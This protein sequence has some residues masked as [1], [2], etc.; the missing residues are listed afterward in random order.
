MV[1]V[2]II[3]FADF[4][5][6]ALFRTHCLYSQLNCKSDIEH[7]TDILIIQMANKVIQM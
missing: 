6:A 7:A 1:S 2:E 4:Y 5:W 3:L